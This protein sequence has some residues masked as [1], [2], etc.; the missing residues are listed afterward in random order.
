MLH[1]LRSG[2]DV[3]RYGF[4]VSRRVGPAVIRNRVKRRLR[5]ATRALLP[6]LEPGWDLA[7]NA[8]QGAGPATLTELRGAVL[9][10]TR[11]AGVL[12]D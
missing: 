4:V 8:R 9:D 11:R 6:R 7:F 1:S 2:R 5:E 3:T 12:R 10:V